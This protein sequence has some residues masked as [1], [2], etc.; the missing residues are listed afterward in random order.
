MDIRLDEQQKLLQS[1]FTRFFAERCPLERVRE[2]EAGAGHD[3]ALWSSLAALGALG[4][5]VPEA[6]GGLGGTFAEAVL[7]CETIGGALYP[8]PFLWTCVLAPYLIERLGDAATHAAWLPRIAQGEAVVALAN[9]QASDPA[10]TPLQALRDADGWRLYGEAR[11][12]EYARHADLLLIAVDAA[13]QVALFLLPPSRAGV[14]LDRR[15]EISGGQFFRVAFDGVAASTAETLAEDARA[16]LEAALDRARVALAARM[17]GAAQRVFDLT[18]AYTRERTQFGQPLLRFQALNFRLAALLTRID[19]ARLL[20]YHAAWL[21]DQGQEFAHAALFA[22]AQAAEVYR[23]MAA[24]AI[25][26]HGGFG[27]TAEASP[28]LFY[29]RAALDAMLLGNATAL[30]ERIASYLELT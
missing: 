8:S 9:D 24:E 13:G 27:F 7:L 5:L 20:A 4:L 6:H 16:P 12:V 23:E 15:S 28:Q 29:R 22:K 11:F 25:Q 14:T 19:G 10:A 1:T 21:I 3:P 30:R 17:V 2:L 26:L 18:L